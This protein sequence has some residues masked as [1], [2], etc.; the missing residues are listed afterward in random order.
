[1]YKELISMH[2]EKKLDFKEVKTFNLD[3]YIGLNKDNPN[4]YYYL[5]ALC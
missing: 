5:Y 4:S 2:R 3:K 1:M